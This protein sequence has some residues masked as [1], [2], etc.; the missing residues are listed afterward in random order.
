[1]KWSAL[2]AMR[3]GSDPFPYVAHL[4][5]GFNDSLH[6][7]IRWAITVI[8]S[9]PYLDPTYRGEGVRRASI[10]PRFYVRSCSEYTIPADLVSITINI[11]GYDTCL[12][13]TIT[14]I[15]I[16]IPKLSGGG[17]KYITS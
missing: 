17:V 6:R 1:M 16:N 13:K 8:S 10:M 12:S 9:S 2:T 5:T 3:A 7:I 4:A 11:N 15:D 14:R